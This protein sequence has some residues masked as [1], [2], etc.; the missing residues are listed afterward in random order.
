MKHWV[1]NYVGKP[2]EDGGRGPDSYD[3]WG[4]VVSVYGRVYGIDLP[5]YGEVSAND[6]LAAARCMSMDSVC[7]PWRAVTEPEEPDV[8]LLAGYAPDGKRLRRLPVHV[9]V[10]VST[11]QLLHVESGINTVLVPLTHLSVRHRVLG[12]YRHESR[13]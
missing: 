10:V 9:G 8:A 5:T 1:F 6:L 3:C 4:L 12:Y 7:S 13:P 11:N 2:F